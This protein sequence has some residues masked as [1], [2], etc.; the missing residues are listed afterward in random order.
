MDGRKALCDIKRPGKR[1]AV[2]D[3]C[4]AEIYTLV[5]FYSVLYSKT[6]SVAVLIRLSFSNSLL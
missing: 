5:F 1:N 4:G 6:S 2:N 3:I